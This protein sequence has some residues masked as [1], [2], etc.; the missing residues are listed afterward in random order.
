MYKLLRRGSGRMFI[1]CVVLVSL[2]LCLY[3]V[4]QI[5][6]PATGP[7]SNLLNDV[8]DRGITPEVLPNY[9]EEPDS[10]ISTAACP[11]IQPRTS[12]IDAQEQ[13]QKFDFQ[14]S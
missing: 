4:S 1:L 12:D 8:F 6:T 7:V 9:T 13:F 11:V 2:L 3:Y 10:K 14:V 5:Q